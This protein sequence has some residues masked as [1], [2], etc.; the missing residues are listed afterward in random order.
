MAKSS[1][2]LMAR[3][4][5][6]AAVPGVSFQQQ[7]EAY[8][9][10][11]RASLLDICGNDAEINKMKGIVL[12]LVVRSPQ[13][14][15]CEFASLMD[16]M[17]Q[18][19]MLGLYPGPLAECAYLPSGSKAIFVPQFGGLIKLATN[20]GFVK[21][22]SVDVVRKSDVWQHEKGLNPTLRHI[23]DY[24]REPE[25]STRAADKA[26][27]ITLAYCIIETVIGGTQITVKSRK[28]ID[29]S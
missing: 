22:I 17:R 13:L 12:N 20:S 9:S 7:L 8:S 11:Y 14:L 19:L 27:P 24:D 16:C 4:Q 10:K 29:L 25:D 6:A 5:Q 21:S 15:K 23:P 28:W 1:D 2:E 3:T 26:N 18:S